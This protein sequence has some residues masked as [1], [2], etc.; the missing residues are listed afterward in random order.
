MIG[1]LAQ[2]L[3]EVAVQPLSL[4]WEQEYGAADGKTSISSSR[5]T[6][7]EQEQSYKY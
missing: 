4:L 6:K 5:S 1:R 3:L 2:A 7:D